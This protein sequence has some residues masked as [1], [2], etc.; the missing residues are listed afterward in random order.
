MK[1]KNPFFTTFFPCYCL[2]MKMVFVVL[3]PGMA[4]VSSSRLIQSISGKPSDLPGSIGNLL[5]PGQSNQ[6]ILGK[7]NI[8]IFSPLFL[9]NL[10]L[11]VRFCL[12]SLTLM[13]N[14]F[15]LLLFCPIAN[16]IYVIYIVYLS[17]YL[18][19]YLYMYT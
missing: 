15:Q 12:T 14:I 9:I 3:Q 11:M 18:Y 10:L 5:G 6:S 8:K 1:Y 19:F 13:G 17:I 7:Q 16:L 4:V 2:K